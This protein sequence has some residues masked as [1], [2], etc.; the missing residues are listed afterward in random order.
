MLWMSNRGRPEFPWQGQH[1]ALGAEPVN[2]VFDL[3]R[4]ARPPAGH[5]LADRLG[6]AL[7]AGK[8]WRT[9]YRIAAWS[10]AVAPYSW[11]P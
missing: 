9:R 10:G 3:G 11:Q 7:Q 4:V 8:T 5:P 6:I 1:V 2:S